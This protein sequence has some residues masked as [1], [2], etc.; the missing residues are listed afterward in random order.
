[1]S[2]AAPTLGPPPIAPESSRAERE[3]KVDA[4]SALEERERFMARRA[5]RS[6]TNGP[7]AQDHGMMWRSCSSDKRGGVEGGA[8]AAAA[9]LVSKGAEEGKTR[10]VKFADE[11]V[12]EAAPL[13]GHGRRSGGG[14]KSR[15]PWIVVIAILILS[16]VAALVACCCSRAGP[17]T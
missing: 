4:G 15:F 8:T 5:M 3:D 9:P 10:K 11:G 12:R 1:M 16:C 7:A 2:S 14:A 13:P 6:G 17:L